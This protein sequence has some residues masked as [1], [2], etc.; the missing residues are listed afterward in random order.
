MRKDKTLS[1]S[2]IGKKEIREWLEIYRVDTLHDISDNLG[3]DDDQEHETFNLIFRPF[4]SWFVS[5]QTWSASRFLPRPRTRPTLL[6]GEAEQFSP[7][8]FHF[9]L[10][11]SWKF[12]RISL[13]SLEIDRIFEKKFFRTILENSKNFTNFS[14]W[15]SNWNRL[16]WLKFVI[17]AISTGIVDCLRSFIKSAVYIWC[18]RISHLHRDRIFIQELPL[19]VTRIT[20]KLGCIDDTHKDSATPSSPISSSLPPPI[21]FLFLLYPTISATMC[22]NSYLLR[23]TCSP[24]YIVYMKHVVHDTCIEGNGRGWG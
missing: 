2:K 24:V 17:V 6:L 23:A 9:T 13:N 21:I 7:H 1:S 20:F 14:E 22:K 11:K 10:L 18:S 8:N 4:R 19:Y 15:F 16:V 3:D 5:I 12:L